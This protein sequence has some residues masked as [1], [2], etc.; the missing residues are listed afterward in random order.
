MSSTTT[1]LP[2]HADEVRKTRT[3]RAKTKDLPAL[4]E[5]VYQVAAESP[6]YVYQAE[7]GICMHIRTQENPKGCLIGAAAR[8]I[9][10][11]FDDSPDAIEEDDAPWLS[12]AQNR[13][14][15]GYSWGEVVY[16]NAPA[17]DLH[18]FAF[19]VGQQDSNNK[20]ATPG[21]ARIFNPNASHVAAFYR[22]RLAGKV[23]SFA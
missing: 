3:G 5:A 16:E 17:E 18:R 1:E 10:E 19:L 6:L 7:D 23:G 14:D 21:V 4:I 15:N 11:N 13:Q 9:G 20:R 8:L 2:L 22:G 12:S